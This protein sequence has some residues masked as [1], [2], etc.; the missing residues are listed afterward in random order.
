[1]NKSTERVLMILFAVL[2]VG[3]AVLFLSANGRNG[4]LIR[5]KDELIAQDETLKAENAEAAEKAAAKLK[6]VTE[7]RDDLEAELDEAT[8]LNTALTLESEDAAQQI[9]EHVQRPHQPRRQRMDAALF[10]DN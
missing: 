3:F 1:M 5:E 2:A 9:D 4:A 8:Q 10:A 6:E 7:Q